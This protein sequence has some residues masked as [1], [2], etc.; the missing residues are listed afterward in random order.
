MLHDIAKAEGQK[1]QKDFTILLKA[2]GCNQHHWRWDLWRA[3][4]SVL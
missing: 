3:H 1:L 4:E 2:A